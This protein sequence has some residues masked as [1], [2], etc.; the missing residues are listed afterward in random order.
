MSLV[1]E[2]NNPQYSNLKAI[3]LLKEALSITDVAQRTDKLIQAGSLIALTVSQYET[4]EEPRKAGKGNS[5]RSK[6]ET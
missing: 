2:L 1:V 4:N 5:R 3:E 6:I